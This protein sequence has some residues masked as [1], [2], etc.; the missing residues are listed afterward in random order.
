MYPYFNIVECQLLILFFVL[1]DVESARCPPARVPSPTLSAA[2]KGEHPPVEENN[3]L[4][5][6]VDEDQAAIAAPQQ[7]PENAKSSSKVA[8]SEATHESASAKEPASQASAPHAE[9]EVQLKATAETGYSC[10]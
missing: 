3:T 8:V 1:S 9:E 5:P 6:V 2:S 4:R 7:T 10:Y